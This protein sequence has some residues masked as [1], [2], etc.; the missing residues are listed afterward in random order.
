MIFLL[1]VYIFD[2]KLMSLR[3]LTDKNGQKG[4]FFGAAVAVTDLDNDGLVLLLIA[5]RCNNI[6]HTPSLYFRNSS[7]GKSLCRCFFH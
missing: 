4:Q 7:L 5:W 1:Q 3:N 6:L 2:N